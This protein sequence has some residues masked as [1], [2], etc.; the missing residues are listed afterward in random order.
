VE[1][2]FN[3]SIEM[4]ASEV[5]SVIEKTIRSGG[6]GY[7]CSVEAN[8]LTIANMNP[9]FRQIINSAL[10]NNCDG[11]VLAMLL[12][13]IYKRPYKPYVGA[14]LFYKYVCKACYRQYFLGNT[15]TVLEGLRSRLSEADAAVAGM[16]FE[17]LPF[18]TVDGFDYPEI[19]DRINEDNPDIIWV[20]LGAP[21]QE[22]FMSRL[23]PFLNRGVMFGFGAIFNFYSGTDGVRRAPLWMRRLRLEW[24]YRAMEEPKKNIPR[25]ARFLR[26][27]PGLISNERRI[28]ASRRR[29]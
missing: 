29:K 13:R 19:A 28:A 21:K 3:V 23:L 7:V 24:L 10:V 17:E 6:K 12:S 15:K 27:L 11:S 26:I 5:D 2:F 4:D 14:D 25:Y 22:E 9:S 16:R 18:R 20:S 1:Q 8:N